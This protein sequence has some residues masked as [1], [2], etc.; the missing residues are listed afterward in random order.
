MNCDECLHYNV[1]ELW[2]KEEGKD[3]SNITDPL[4]D[5]GCI[6][7]E[8]ARGKRGVWKIRGDGEGWLY[9][10][11]YDCPC[12]D[13]MVDVLLSEGEPSFCPNCGAKMITDW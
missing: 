7:F 9:Y 10:I 2:R 11:T 12:C 13:K 3:A 6:C 5:H 4:G 8:S 1:C